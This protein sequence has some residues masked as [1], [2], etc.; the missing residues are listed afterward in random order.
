MYAGNC[1]IFYSTVLSKYIHIHCCF[2]I[3]YIQHPVY[4]QTKKVLP[5]STGRNFNNIIILYFVLLIIITLII[6]T[7]DL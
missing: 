2:K 1:F 5:P 4:K 3:Q 6:L 7:N